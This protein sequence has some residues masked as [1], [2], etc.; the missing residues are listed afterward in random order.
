MMTNSRRRLT[1]MAGCLARTPFP[2][3][4]STAAEAGFEAI[5]LWPNIWRHARHKLGMSLAQ[6]RGLLDAHGLIC[7]DTGA[8]RDWVPAPARDSTQFGPIKGSI[9]RE[10]FFE[11]TAALGG[12]TVVAVHM[13][14]AAL[15][16]DRDTESFARLCDDAARYGLR[17]ALEFVP[18]SQV[19]NMDT[20]LR[21]VEGAGRANG[22]LVLDNWHHAHSGGSL[23]SLRRLPP[24]RVFTIQI[25]DSPRHL[26][27][28]LVEEAMHHRQWPGQGALDVAG[29]LHTL[30]Q[31]GVRCP[32]GL[33]LY[34]AD[35]DTQPVSTVMRR[36]ANATR[37]LLNPAEKH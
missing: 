19:P 31:L 16:L 1:F 25:S 34:Q 21:I 29:F 27:R 8:V 22:G 18:F 6:M 26:S 5:T 37:Q 36:L 10:E 33:E 15:D 24:E 28:P 17:I 30:D 11:V 20:A 23:D 35:F 7:T 4:V 12:S 2:E 3:L 13:T 32:I 9:P 14:D